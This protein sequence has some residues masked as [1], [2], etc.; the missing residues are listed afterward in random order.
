MGLYKEGKILR[1]WQ[2]ETW[3]PKTVAFIQAH[4]MHNHGRLHGILGDG[5]QV[6][7]G[8]QGTPPLR[9]LPEDP[10]PDQST[11]HNKALGGE[12]GMSPNH[13]LSPREN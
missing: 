13:E 4:Q 9:T 11:C 10:V 7:T 1:L 6:A 5:E 12:S 2:T 8:P 3:R